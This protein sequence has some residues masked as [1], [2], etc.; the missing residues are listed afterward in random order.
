VMVVASILLPDDEVLYVVVAG[1]ID[2]VSDAVFYD[3]AASSLI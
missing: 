2:D 1:L 3:I